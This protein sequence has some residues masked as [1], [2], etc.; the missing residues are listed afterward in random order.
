MNT[1][2]DERAQLELREQEMREMIVK[3]EDKRS[4]FAAFREWIES[5]ATFL[6]EKV[7]C[8]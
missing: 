6:D 7:R 1:L 2:A 4:W 3:A 5:V 8:R